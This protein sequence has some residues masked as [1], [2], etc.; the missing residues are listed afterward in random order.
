MTKN[1]LALID[2]ITSYLNKYMSTEKTTEIRTLIGK[3]SLLHI[4]IEQSAELTPKV[5][6]IDAPIEVIEK[7]AKEAI[8]DFE[9]IKKE[10][11]IQ[12]E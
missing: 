4:V 12:V 6:T 2:Q 11:G 7:L 9:V 8:T 10:Q 1:Q 3:V 5:K